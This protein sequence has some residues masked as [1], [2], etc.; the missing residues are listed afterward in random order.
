M[1]WSSLVNKKIINI[2]KG[3]KTILRGEMDMIIKESGCI[4][5]LLVIP[6]GGY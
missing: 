4:D 6:Q 3:D 2:I 5:S 1:R